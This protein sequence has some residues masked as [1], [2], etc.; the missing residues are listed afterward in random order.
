MMAHRGEKPHICE[1]CKK[2]CRTEQNLKSHMATHTNERHFKCTQCKKSF[3]FSYDL[4]RHL[5]THLTNIC[6]MCLK[7]FRQAKSLRNHILYYRSKHTN[8]HIQEIH[9][10]SEDVQVKEEGP[11]DIALEEGE[12]DVDL[13]E[14]EM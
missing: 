8:F 11:M 1:D 2:T 7:I 3:K 9:K 12:F 4:K 13:E 10:Q 14:G 5:T 6:K